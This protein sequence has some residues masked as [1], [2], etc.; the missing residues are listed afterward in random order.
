[1]GDTCVP[2]GTMSNYGTCLA[3]RMRPDGGGFPMRDGGVA[4]H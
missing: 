3:V 4:G 1:M 2:T